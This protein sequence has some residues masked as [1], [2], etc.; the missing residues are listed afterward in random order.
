M[1]SVP[2][3]ED[4]RGRALSFCLCHVRTQKAAAV[5]K[6]GTAFSPEPEHAAPDLRPPAYRLWKTSVCCLSWPVVF[7]LLHLS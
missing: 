4:A 2:S 7:V 5:P 1:R 3:Q 6:A